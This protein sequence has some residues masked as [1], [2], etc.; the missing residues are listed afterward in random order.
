M[1]ELY[2]L[3]Y[4]KAS[5]ISKHRSGHVSTEAVIISLDQKVLEMLY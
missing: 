4:I 5:G 1:D 2:L 3:G